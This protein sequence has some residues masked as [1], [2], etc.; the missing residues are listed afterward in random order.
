MTDYAAPTARPARGDTLR[1]CL[2]GLVICDAAVVYFVYRVKTRA[3]FRLTV[4][5]LSRNR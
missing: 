3:A 2:S 4:A 1:A 5:T